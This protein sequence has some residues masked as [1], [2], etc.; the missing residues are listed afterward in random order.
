GDDHDDAAAGDA[1]TPTSSAATTGATG[2]PSGASAATPTTSAGSASTTAS[3]PAP[4]TAAAAGAGDV[5][6][7]GPAGTL[8]AYVAPAAA[9]QPKGPVLVIP[10]TRGLPDHFRSLSR[11]FAAEGYTALAL[12]LASRAGGSAA[13]GDE[14]KVTAA[15]GGIAAADLVADMGAGIDELQ[16]RA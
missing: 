11:R 6:F 15:L 9:A 10:E 4:S 3:G 1:T 14:G 16:R 5:T 13:I 2:A 8:H 12:D 7:T